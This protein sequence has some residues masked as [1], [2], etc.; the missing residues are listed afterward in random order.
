MLS[1][2]LRQ[3]CFFREVLAQLDHDGEAAANVGV[4]LSDMDRHAV[5]LL[6]P[7]M[8]F[9]SGVCAWEMPWTWEKVARTYSD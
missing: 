4:S 2:H 1:A 6:I 8:L 3:E 7:W 5:G 9:G